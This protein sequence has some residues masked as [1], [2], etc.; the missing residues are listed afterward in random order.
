MPIPPRIQEKR[1][2]NRMT[3]L[4]HA[5]M[6]LAV[7]CEDDSLRESTII[8][9]TCEFMCSYNFSKLLADLRLRPEQKKE[10][11]C[12]HMK[13]TLWWYSSKE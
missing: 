1:T 2:I 4:E 7:S 10:V 3:L 9:E 5:V 13:A 6:Y 12:G 11:E 8:L